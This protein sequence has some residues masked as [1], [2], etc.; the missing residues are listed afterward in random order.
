MSKEDE[1]FDNAKIKNVDDEPDLSV[2]E[3][4]KEADCKGLAHKDKGKLQYGL[5]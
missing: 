3:S 1:E 5:L 4:K 2:S